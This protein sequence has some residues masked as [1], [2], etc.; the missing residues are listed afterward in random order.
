MHHGIV[1]HFMG[2]SVIFPDYLVDNWSARADEL[3][4]AGLKVIFTGHFHA[5][6]AIQRYYWATYRW[7]ILKQV[8]R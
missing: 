2:E 7:L 1:E 6:D 4:Q 3:M 5:N 8:H